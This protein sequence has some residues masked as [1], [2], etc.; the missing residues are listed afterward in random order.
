MTAALL[1]LFCFLSLRASS[2]VSRKPFPRRVQEVFRRFPQVRTRNVFLCVSHLPPTSLP[3]PFV[4]I[5]CVSQ[6]P[7]APCLTDLQHIIQQRLQSARSLVDKFLTLD[8]SKRI[9]AKDALDADYFWEEPMPCLPKDLP[10]YEP[11]HE[12]QTRKRRQVGNGEYKR[13]SLAFCGIRSNIVLTLPR[14]Y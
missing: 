2:F 6:Q 11:S 14:D 13:R 12:F 8:P 1:C 9:S 7:V 4:S 3:V 5:L 10:K